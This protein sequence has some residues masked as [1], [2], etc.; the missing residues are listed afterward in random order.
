[1][2]LEIAGDEYDGTPSNNKKTWTF[3]NIEVSKSGRIRLYVDLLEDAS[4]EG[5]S[6]TFSI[7]GWKDLNYVDGQN[8][9]K[10]DVSGSLNI[11]KLTLTQARGTLVNNL[12]SS[13]DIEFPNKELNTFTIFDGTYT[14]KKQ[15]INLNSFTIK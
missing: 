12:S 1:M 9:D 11:S 14:A 4:A 13:E 2:R 5:K 15:N 7:D 3:D 8:T 6:I 10:I